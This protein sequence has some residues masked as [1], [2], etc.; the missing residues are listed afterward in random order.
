MPTPNDQILD[1][2]V[3]LD[4]EEDEEEQD[5]EQEE[6]EEEWED[7]WDKDGDD[8][9][10]EE[11]W[12]DDQDEE[13]WEDD[14]DDEKPVTRKEYKQLQRAA[15]IWVQKVLNK[16]KILDQA[17]SALATVAEDPESL[18]TIHE[19]NPEVSKVIL[20]K[21][22]DG[23]SIEEYAEQWLGKEY[24]PNKPQEKIDPDAIRKEEREKIQQ[25][26]VEEHV[27]KLFEKTNLS[28]EEKKK[29]KEEYNDL[30]EGKKLTKEKATK[31]FQIAYSL[32]RKSPKLDP[33][34]KAVKSTA[35]TSSGWSEKKK[36]VVDP[37]LKDAEEFLEENGYY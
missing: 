24:K 34:T 20:D 26:Q 33:I 22:Y 6:Q 9:Q 8:E 13:G 12:D 3:D 27:N 14:D 35:P 7:W 28:K 37:Y 36:K 4:Y 17:F 25:E 5:E 2:D 18:I 32:V 11:D 23:I 15:S 1:K 19:D 29:V 16:N 31:Y 10:E 21:Y 30:A